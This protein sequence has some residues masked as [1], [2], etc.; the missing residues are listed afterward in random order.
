MPSPTE[1]V[2]VTP[3]VLKYLNS[4]PNCKAIKI[5][6]GPYMERATPDI[7]GCLDGRSFLFECKRPGHDAEPQQALRLA[8]WAAAGAITGVVHSVA[9]VQRILGEQ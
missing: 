9:E 4:L 7:M 1:N 3:K 5:H 6:G 8:Q 2:S